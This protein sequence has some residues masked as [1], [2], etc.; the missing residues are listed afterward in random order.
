MPDQQLRLV[1]GSDRVIMGDW[2][3]CV[4]IGHVFALGCDSKLGL[5][6]SEIHYL[7]DDSLSHYVG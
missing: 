4:L 2:R 1:R 7:P 5:R 6:K 3:A